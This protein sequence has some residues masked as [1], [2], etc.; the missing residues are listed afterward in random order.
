VEPPEQLGGQ[1]IAASGEGGFDD[2]RR[3]SGHG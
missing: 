2:V 3:D 1:G